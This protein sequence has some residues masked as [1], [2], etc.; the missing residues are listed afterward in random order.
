VEVSVVRQDT[1]TDFPHRWPALAARLATAAPPPDLELGRLLSAV[2][3]QRGPED[4]EALVKG[5]VD[6]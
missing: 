2:A 4:P 3:L 6:A 1:P 5:A